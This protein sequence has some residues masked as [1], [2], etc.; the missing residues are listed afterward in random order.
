MAR[1]SPPA[2]GIERRIWLIT[3]TAF[4]DALPL[5]SIVAFAQSSIATEC[6]SITEMVSHIRYLGFASSDLSAEPDRFAMRFTTLIE[7]RFGQPLDPAICD[8]RLGRP[9][10]ER[11]RSTGFDV[12][13]RPNDSVRGIMSSATTHL[14]QVARAIDATDDAGDIR[15]I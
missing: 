7:A 14:N 12:S 1:S 10:S 15:R 11:Q 9:A 6:S 8:S 4:A 3:G 13:A 5:K 2:R